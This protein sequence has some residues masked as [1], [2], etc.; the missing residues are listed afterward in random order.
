[1]LKVVIAS[2]KGGTGKSSTT[3]NLGYALKRKGYKVGLL[4]VDCVAPT[5]TTALGLSKLPGWELNAAGDGGKGTV[6]PFEIDGIYA[7]TMASHYGE[8]PAVLWD[9]ETLIDAIRQLSTGLVQWPE[10]LD[11]ILMDSPPSSS[12]FMQALF[13][14]IP[15]LHGVILVFQPTDMAAA[16]LWRSL[17]FLKFKRVP[18]LGLISNMAYALSPSGEKFWPFLSP[19]VDLR[20]M[21]GKFGIPMLGEIPLTSDRKVIDQAFDQIAIGLDGVKPIILKEDIA[22]RLIRAGKKKLLKAAV[23]R[24]RPWLNK[25]NRQ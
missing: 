4:D 19:K 24:Q 22:K 14:Y 3:V 10:S 6:L 25:K 7:L 12:K 16:D 20:E 21:C 5:L 18:I 11:Y 17:D 23:R 9:E 8:T 1:M 13:D 15:E 2:L